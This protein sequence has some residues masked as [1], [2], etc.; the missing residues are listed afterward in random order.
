M[1]KGA[2]AYLCPCEVECYYPH[3]VFGHWSIRTNLPKVS[4]TEEN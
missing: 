4:G 2:E 1:V 3:I